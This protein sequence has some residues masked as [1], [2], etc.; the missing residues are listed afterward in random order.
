MRHL[1]PEVH[2]R[3]V[4]QFLGDVATH[5][6]TVLKDDGLYRH[7]RFGRPGT[8]CMQFDLVTWP[9]YL[10]YVGD[11][12]EFVFERLPDMF[13]FFR[14]KRD[15]LFW[16]D[17]QYWA[18][19]CRAQDKSDGITTFDEDA[20]TATVNEHIEMATEGWSDDDKTDLEQEIHVVLNCADDEHAAFEAVHEFSH[21][22]ERHDFAFD[23]F[24][25]NACKVYTPRFW[26]CC[27]ALSWGIDCYDR[28]REARGG[29]TDGVL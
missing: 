4:T 20:F 2:A 21:A 29:S 8:R 3:N 10:A 24:N 15:E 1:T 18:E 22:G 7:L 17:F 12:G 16:I 13:Q 27:F 26:W 6:L 19:K 14:R 23:D 5:E 25:Y 9:G 11:M 28:A